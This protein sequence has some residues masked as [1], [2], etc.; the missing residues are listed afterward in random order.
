LCGKGG[1]DPAAIDCAAC[2]AL[3]ERLFL[4]LNRMLM[5]KWTI[6]LLLIAIVAGILGFTG[7]AIGAAKIAKSLFFIFLV[8]FILSLIRGKS[9]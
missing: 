1:T 2:Y 9:G 6:I 3:P 7:I 4:P 8:L 5:L